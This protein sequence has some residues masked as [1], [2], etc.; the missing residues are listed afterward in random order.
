MARVCFV[1]LVFGFSVVWA[2]AE[3]RSVWAAAG[4]LLAVAFVLLVAAKMQRDARRLKAM[5]DIETEDD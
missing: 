1:A 4:K 3:S 5:D 2:L